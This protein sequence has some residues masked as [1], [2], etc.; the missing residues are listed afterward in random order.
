[1]KPRH[2]AAGLDGLIWS[3]ALVAWLKKHSTDARDKKV[4]SNEIPAKNLSLRLTNASMLDFELQCNR[5][6]V[7]NSRLIWSLDE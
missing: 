7:E 5:L 3:C 1:L 4:P 6:R 2:A